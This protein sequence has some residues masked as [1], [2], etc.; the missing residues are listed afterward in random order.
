MGQYG[1]VWALYGQAH[2]IDIYA[3]FHLADFL[4]FLNT[5]F[6]FKIVQ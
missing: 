3:Y 5:A 1:Q 6:S 2:Y 4:L